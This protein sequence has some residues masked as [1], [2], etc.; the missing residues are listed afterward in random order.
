MITAI[1]LCFP[2]IVLILFLP[3]RPFKT[4]FFLIIKTKRFVN[5]QKLIY[6][7]LMHYVR[8]SVV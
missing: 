4:N 1:S 8:I 5:A 2:L 3:L 6:S 7:N